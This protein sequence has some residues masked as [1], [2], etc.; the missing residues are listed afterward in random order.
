M[1]ALQRPARHGMFWLAGGFRLVRQRPAAMIAIVSGYWFIVL[2]LSSL[3]YVGSVLAS[4]VIP[5]LF[6][7]VMNACRIAADGAPPR[8]DVLLSGFRG[9]PARTRAL[10]AMGALYLALT[11]V[12]LFLSSLIDGGTLMNVM[13]GRPVDPEDLQAPA[14]LT[15]AQLALA[16]MAPVLMAWWYAPLLAAWHGVPLVKAL[17]FSFV[18]CWRNWRAFLVYSLAA[19]AFGL[20]LLILAAF[21][22]LGASVGPAGSLQI[23]FIIAILVLAPVYFASFYFTYSDVFNPAPAEPPA[24]GEHVD[25]EA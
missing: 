17:F 5:A 15:A 10:L 11:I 8:L 12:V 13:T 25:T 20:P 7:G 19:A 14:F 22:L 4:I 2:F 18:A 1:Q 23:L 3:P 24:P 21:A 16:L 9:E 6:V